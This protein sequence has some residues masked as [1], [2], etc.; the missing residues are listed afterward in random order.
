[1]YDLDE[2]GETM[3]AQQISMVSGVAQV[4]VFGSQKYAVRIQLD[5]RQLAARQIGIDDVATAIDE[6]NVNAPLG[7][8]RGP[9]KTV[10]IQ[11]NSQ[12]ADASHFRSL[13]VSYRNGQP[14]RLSDLGVVLDD[15]ENN[16]SAA[17]YGKDGQVQRS[18]I[19]AVSKQPGSNTV[20]VADA[21]KALLPAFRSKLP[22]SVSLDVLRDG[23]VSIRQSANDVQFTLLLTLGL[24]VMVIFLFLR[25][26]RATVIPSLTLPLS[27]VGTF[28]VMY[29]LGYSLDNLSL[30][31]LTLS[32]GFVV[33]DAIVMLENVVRHME[34]GKTRLQAAFDG[35]KE[36]GFTII[37]MTLSLAAVFIPVL[38]MSGIVGR[39]FREF[40]VSIGVAVLVSGVVSLTLTPMLCS[41]FLR[42][43]HRSHPGLLYRATEAGL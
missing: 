8:L 5:P 2:L 39:L 22:G 23:S 12:M 18:I 20:E 34:M 9:N 36:I 37:S 26:I 21:V 7:N 31:A 41:R 1:M 42:D 35:S 16:Q 10:S 17:W 33:D 6:N 40:S 24:V 15:V 25:N 4:Q 11:S 43:T 27:I 28:A 19:L 13:I 30:M 38:F 32:V 3:M 14:V 29:L